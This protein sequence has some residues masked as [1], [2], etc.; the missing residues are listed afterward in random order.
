MTR[1][2]TTLKK[3]LELAGSKKALC[4]ALWLSYEELEDYLA[5]NKAVP[6]SVAS[7]AAKIVKESKP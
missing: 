7:A 3:A 6:Q 2:Q 1:E 5:G 4:R